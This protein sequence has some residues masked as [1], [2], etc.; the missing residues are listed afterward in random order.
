LTLER[1]T[2]RTTRGAI[3]GDRAA[4]AWRFLGIPYAAPPTGP[5]R[6]RAP[7]PAPRW[8]GVRD[9]L[10]FGPTAP[11]PPRTLPAGLDGRPVMG[12]GWVGGDDYLTVNVWTPDPGARGLP[13]MVYL[14]GGAFVAGAPHA[15]IYDGTS[16]ARDG[17][18]LVSATY[19][20][21]VEGFV[22]L[23]G[24][25]ANCGLRDQLAVLTWVQEEI[26]G[27]GG[28]PGNVTLFGQSAGAICADL[29][30]ASPA[31][32]G[33]M[34]RVIS[35]SG[36]LRLT[37]GPR[38]GDRL[39]TAI[40]ARLGVEPTRD[41]MSPMRPQDTIAAQ[42]AVR[43]QD[44]DLAVDS[45]PGLPDGFGPI[46]PVRDGELVPEDPL[47]AVRA[48]VRDGVDLLVGVTADDG[49]LQ[50]AATNAFP[51][52]TREQLLSVAAGVHPHPGALLTAYRELHA[53]ATAR[54]LAV[55]IL[56]DCFFRLPTAHL[57]DAHSATGRTF[58]YELTWRSSALGG[59]L[60]AAHAIDLPFVFD[61]LGVP[62]ITGPHGLLGDAGA[63]QELAARIHAAWVAFA[64]TG[65][66]GWEPWTA[67]RPVVVG[68]DSGPWAPLEGAWSR[69]DAPWTALTGDPVL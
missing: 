34:R 28:D 69:Q 21:G 39:A 55:Q 7:V 64:R 52:P 32:R 6:F 46:A 31:S 37:L 35:Q 60:G 67:A 29:L 5:L 33:L 56:T 54:D 17:V 10:G 59:A 18:V 8:T 13:V 44:V 9:C 41:A 1:A 53:E 11:Q 47:A 19:R 40:A 30:L 43:S 62:G 15:P 51:D 26:A 24:G 63:P 58:A 42:Q 12:P 4:A 3:R 23:R 61:A 45:E 16:F 50:L 27:F 38:Q 22:P 14:H 65:E 49:A 48:R 66:P 25:D 57:A 36:G 2:V 68:L 20:L